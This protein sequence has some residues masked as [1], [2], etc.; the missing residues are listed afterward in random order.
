M[1]PAHEP[2]APEIDMI[3]EWAGRLIVAAVWGYAFGALIDASE[4]L[5]LAGF[6]WVWIIFWSAAALTWF[7]SRP[8]KN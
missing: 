7:L 3:R 4:G 1:D 6:I 2:A 5:T 8:R